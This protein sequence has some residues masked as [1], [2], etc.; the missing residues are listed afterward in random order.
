MAENQNEKK[1][2]PKDITPNPMAAA[3]QKNAAPA[4]GQPGADAPV[5][6]AGEEGPQDMKGALKASFIDSQTMNRALQFVFI[7]AGLVGMFLGFRG[8]ILSPIPAASGMF[9]LILAALLD[10]YIGKKFTKEEGIGTLTKIILAGVFAA[11]M[12]LFIVEI[13]RK[14]F[15]LP[16]NELVV[17]L[18]LVVVLIAGLVRIILYIRKNRG[19]IVADIQLL[20]AFVLAVAAALAFNFYLVVPSFLFAAAALVLVIMSVTKDPIAGDDRSMWRMRGIITIAVIFLA[21]LAYA[22]TIFFSKPVDVAL[23]GKISPTYKTLPVNLTWSGDS[24]SF[25]YNLSGKNKNE[26]T[27][28]VINSLSRG[29]NTLPPDRSQEASES[30]ISLSMPVIG[31]ENKKQAEANLAE[32]KADKA[33]TSA[34]KEA[35]EDIKL[36]KYLDPP[37]FNN[38]GNFLIFSGS[39]TED[40]PRNIWGVSLTLTLME[41]ELSKEEKA[42]KEKEAD[43]TQDELVNYK[44][45]KRAELDKENEPVG[46]PKLVVA[47][48]NKV[49]DM[50]C[51]P[52]TH[53]TAWSPDGKSFCFDA[54]NKKGVYNVWS[55]DTKEQTMGKVTK[56]DEKVM[57]LWSPNGD[58][59]LYC[60]K[61]DSYTYLKIADIDGKH[62]HEL[63]IH[64]ARD[65]ALFPLWNAAESKVIYLKKGKLIIMNASATDQKELG[66]GTLTPS[67]YWLTEKKKQIT[68]QYTESGTIWRIFT[69]KPNGRKNKQIF[70]EVCE[71]LAQPKWSYDG[72]SVVTAANYKEDS[73]MWRLDKDGK[74]KTRIYTTKHKISELEWDSTSKRIAFI[75]KKTNVSSVWWDVFK[76]LFFGANPNTEELWVV[77]NDG[78]NPMDLYTARKMIN[79]MSWNDQGTKLAFDETYHVIYFQPDIT[80][81]KIVHAIGGEK[82]DLLPYEFYGQ[83]PTWSANGH[84]LAY[85]S[86]RDFWKMSL[87]DEYG[88]WVAQLK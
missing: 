37:L 12:V 45:K 71:N 76:E 31:K 54:A 79:H 16:L 33:E 23:Y 20:I 1:D 35:S 85:I 47:D 41:K 32:K 66:R 9:A 65:K 11:L 25:A 29:I 38:K 22:S 50:D 7:F 72:S 73:S 55:S 81:V 8:Q 75:V 42:E 59:L 26:S 30:G 63:N 86:W 53:K 64:N 60:S 61:T 52:L 2:S 84:V 46:K 78:T 27:V 82:W 51:K 80:V 56:G 68:L 36:P 14:P 62:S 49:I 21:I 13:F 69:I 4:E 58:K 40:G 43:M 6:P 83:S 70:E 34:E 3:E 28:N 5:E 39:D 77:N 15:G 44:A 24:W 57:P 10:I 87:V 48:I 74:F 88:L 19:Q 67:P 18:A 17:A